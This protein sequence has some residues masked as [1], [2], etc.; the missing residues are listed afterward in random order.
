LLG[1]GAGKLDAELEMVSQELVLSA[2]NISLHLHGSTRRS[3][4]TPDVGHQSSAHAIRYD[5]LQIVED[6]VEDRPRPP[7][8]QLAGKRDG[9]QAA[10]RATPFA[11]LAARQ[12]GGFIVAKPDP[13]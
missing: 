7:G 12:P 9:A 8:F 4:P 10:E 5:S 6:L 3:T 11:D 13:E 2:I 1:G